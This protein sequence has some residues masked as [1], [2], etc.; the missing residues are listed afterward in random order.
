MVPRTAVLRAGLL[1]GRLLLLRC[2]L[3]GLGL[4]LRL[5]LGSRVLALGLLGHRARLGLGSRRSEGGGRGLRGGG[6]CGSPVGERANGAGLLRHGRAQV[7]GATRAVA[8]RAA[9]RGRAL[10][11]RL[12]R[13]RL[14]GRAGGAEVGGPRVALRVLRTLTLLGMAHSRRLRGILRGVRRLYPGS[15][16]RLLR[17]LP[18]LGRLLSGTLRL[19][20][21]LCLSGSRGLRVVRVGIRL[22]PARE[23]RSGLDR[24]H[25]L[26]VV[27]RRLLR[28]VTLPGGLR[29]PYLLLGPAGGLL[30]LRRLLLAPG[31]L[32][33]RHQQQVFVVLL[34]ERGL[35][36]GG[37]G[38]CG[39]CAA[40]AVGRVGEGVGAGGRNVRLS[41][42]L[43]P[44]CVLRQP[45]FRDLTGVSHAFPLPIASAPSNPADGPP[46]PV[47]EERARTRCGTCLR[48]HHSDNDGRTVNPER[49]H[50]SPSAYRAQSAPLAHG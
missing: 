35:V 45:L 44:A 20:P 16:R 30:A 6:G 48:L 14:L 38:G 43:L 40:E 25:L 17:E 27:V 11:G 34:G 23:L 13:L 33:T 37:C 24:R 9:L 15:V 3:L 49:W 46:R 50:N 29:L 2:G 26:L 7:E 10:R 32:G 4:V 28:R 5:H 36:G 22:R 42:P 12:G 19:R 41:L 39:G 8:G 31:A 21:A 18:F 1:R 47:D